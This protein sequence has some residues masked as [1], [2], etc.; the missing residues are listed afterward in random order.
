MQETASVRPTEFRLAHI[1]EARTTLPIRDAALL[2]SSVL[3]S[4]KAKQYPE[5]SL[6]HRLCSTF[7]AHTAAASVCRS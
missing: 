4:P 6:D 7:T 1:C 3:D 2:G 5:N